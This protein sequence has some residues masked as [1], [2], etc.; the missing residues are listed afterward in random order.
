[1]QSTTECRNYHNTA[2]DHVLGLL[3][4]EAADHFEEHLFVCEKCRSVVAQLETAMTNLSRFLTTNPL[5]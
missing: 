4:A 3:P 5:H 2:R 1:M